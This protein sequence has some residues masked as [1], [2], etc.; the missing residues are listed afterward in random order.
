M[1]NIILWL[2]IQSATALNIVSGIIVARVLEPQ[3]F[4]RF[5]TMSAALI[6]TTSILNPLI[7]ELA[8]LVA[9]ERSINM[10]AL[11]RRTLHAALVCSV[12]SLLACLS[13]ASSA[14]QALVVALVI[15]VSLIAQSWATAVL[16]GLNHMVVLGVAQ[17]FG[18]IAKVGLIMAFTTAST[19]WLEVSWAY[20]AGFVLTALVAGFY[21][22]SIPRQTT[23]SWVINWDIVSGFF[24]LALPFSLDQALVQRWFPNSSGPYAALMTYA[25]SVMLLAAPAL[26]IAY[27]SALR[28]SVSS[29][30]YLKQL[31]FF[32]A[33]SFGI[34]GAL[35]I[36]Q[37]FLF[38]LL[39][40]SQYGMVT[41]YVPIALIAI[42]LHVC[43]YSIAQLVIL[44]NQ[45]WFSLALL[46]PISLQ[47]LYLWT[48]ENPSLRALALTNVF[49]F[50][51]QLAIACIPLIHLALRRK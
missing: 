34:V 10:P 39:L 22:S 20:I 26:T 43:A 14:R 31:R 1:R 18:A 25:K 15:P 40:G 13:I 23:T 33:L 38:P 27:S 21:A 49:T 37:P 4:G 28:I 6:M 47:T 41:D 16:T 19:T 42:G 36:F 3:E 17:L 35:W 9:R 29:H 48:L 11:V 50:A 7:N 46:A 8:H 12:V 32:A 51:A 44:R 30:A 45:R 5:A 24:L 2:L